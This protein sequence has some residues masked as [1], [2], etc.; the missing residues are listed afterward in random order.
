V[1]GLACVS[2]AIAVAT[3]AVGG[4]S[5]PSIP[6]LESEI[7]ELR[8]RGEY[9]L[10]V[11]AAQEL[12]A[13]K[14]SDPE[15]DSHE[16][17]DARRQLGILRDIAALPARSRRE[18]AGADSLTYVIERCFYA[19]RFQDGV[20][21][22]DQQLEIRRRLLGDRHFD[23]AETLVN[24][25]VLKV[26]R[27]ELATAQTLYGEVLAIARDWLEPHHPLI[28]DTLLR[29]G[30]VLR[31]QGDYEGAEP[32]L[33]EAVGMLSAL[34]GDEHQEIARGL[35]ELGRLLKEDGRYSEAQSV[36][37]EA[38]RMRRGLLG[39]HHPDV[40][41]TLV[42]LGQ[43]R[44]IDAD[45]EAAERCYEEALAIRR[46]H[47]GDEHL[48]VAESLNNLATLYLERGNTL[49]QRK[50]AN[51]TRQA[52]RMVRNL[53]GDEHR[54]V[55]TCMTNAGWALESQGDYAGA[56][57]LYR[58][59]L[60]RDRRTYD[61]LVPRIPVDV[62]NLGCVLYL[63]GNLTEADPLLVEALALWR[64]LLDGDH[65]YIATGLNNLAKLK[66]ER[67]EYDEA[68][69]L[70]TEALHM[71]ERL[72]GAGHPETATTLC[73]LGCLLAD[74]GDLAEAELR[75]REAL[76]IRQEHLG[77]QHPL[78]TLVAGNIATILGDKGDLKTAEVIR[79]E[80][81]RGFREA[82]G[83]ESRSVSRSLAR[84]A[85]LL[86]A[87]GANAESESLL[88]EAV[89]IQD[90]AG[91]RR[92]SRQAWA[93]PSSSLHA[94]LA[95]VRLALGAR[96]TAWPA[97]EKSLA[98][99]LT[100]LLVAAKARPLTRAEASREDSLLQQLGENERRLAA[101]RRE[102]AGDTS[103][104]AAERVEL[105]RSE[106]MECEAD[107]S[108]FRRD[109]A[110]KYPMTE[111]HTYT[112]DRVQ[113]ALPRDAAIIG[114]L[115]VEPRVGTPESW[116]YAIRHR[117]S[118]EWRRIPDVWPGSLAGAETEQEADPR[119]FRRSL[120]SPRTP[121][122]DL[123][124]AARS[125]WCLR[126]EPLLDALE[127]VRHL[128]VIPSGRMM[129]VPV[130]ALVDDQGVLLGETFSVS[131]TPSATIHT[132]LAESSDLEMGEA[133]LLL[134]DPPFSPAH[135]AAIGAEENTVVASV[136]YIASPEMFRRALG[137]DDE[138][139][140]S[141]PRLRGTRQEIEAVQ[142]FLHQPFVLLGSDATEQKVVEFVE[143]GRMADFGVMHLAT[144]ALVDDDRPERSALVLS[145]VDLPDAFESAA[146]GTRI[147]D[148]L[149]TANEIVREWDLEADLV[150]LSACETGLGREVRGEGYVGFAHA[151]LQAG[152]RSL[153][154]SLW[155]VDDNATSLLMRRFY[156]N[157]LGES[158][159][160]EALG[161]ERPMSKADAL[162][163]AKQWLRE[164]EDE[165]G[166][167]PYEHPYY[168]GAFILIGDA[169]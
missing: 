30:G 167:H 137:G 111:G 22:A 5:P 129:G 38:L 61:T 125:L 43:L 100:E 85:E 112:L 152:A 16:V 118:V 26:Q 65:P 80:A 95:A 87:R 93:P 12:L 71:E 108:A 142:Q 10:A 105:A 140:R 158:G 44:Q 169:S 126:A 138:A 2:V 136:E 89:R 84:L 63:Q 104:E 48:D 119:S 15:L 4:E 135:A 99:T 117:G 39:G 67:G 60:V 13:L 162:Q 145:Q 66:Q 155:K 29:L 81:L 19:R 157:W 110:A 25:A 49:D 128:V 75:M 154:V 74:T 21:A 83:E 86:R 141:L 34:Y 59:A 90:A 132:W 79:R 161:I 6:A 57:A 97:A 91:T 42:Q 159:G 8:A 153:L 139:L 96:D 114:W 56:E 109:I 163:E 32:M 102:A 27:G 24:L 107:W 31:D 166:S 69:R 150:T 113:S 68:E 20:E 94:Q 82:L 23:V 121:M 131:Y 156:E 148:G 143:S 51:L 7:A 165:Y 14:E 28:A 122:A 36:I 146:A 164:Y 11:E 70:Y 130:E 72:L 73:N 147:Y 151:F 1:Y 77:D 160:T 106:L 98:P 52:L 50:A 149:V 35:D 116:A 133:S 47:W 17:A 46:E 123:D 134:G 33:R 53:L 103:E 54:L 127:G 55:A 40:A 41:A 45:Y 124:A 101:C 3:A 18:L 9:S 120:A 76:A 64:Q 62:N 144:H 92:A 78:T 115:E 58:E 37:A 168:W 88:V